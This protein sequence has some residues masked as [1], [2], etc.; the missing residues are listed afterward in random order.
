MWLIF[1]GFKS[2]CFVGSF[3]MSK[4]DMVEMGE[5]LK[6]HDSA[7]YPSLQSLYSQVESGY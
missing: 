3:Q 7:Y 6:Q 4:P 5:V 2:N 1:C